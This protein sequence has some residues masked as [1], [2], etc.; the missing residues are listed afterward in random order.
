[1]FFLERMIGTIAL[2]III[3]IISMVSEVPMYVFMAGVAF[4]FSVDLKITKFMENLIMQ[5]V[6]KDMD[7]QAMPKALNFEELEEKKDDSERQ[8]SEKTE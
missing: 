2:L 6:M 8:E 5:Q 3:A 1:M 7:S 4:V